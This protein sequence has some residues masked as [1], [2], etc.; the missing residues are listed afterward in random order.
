MTVTLNGE[1]RQCQEGWTVAD[2][3]TELGL[4]TRRIAVEVNREIIPREDYPTH[5]LH[6]GDAVEIVQFVGGG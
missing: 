3:V 2:L 6:T 4:R 5:R 1:Q